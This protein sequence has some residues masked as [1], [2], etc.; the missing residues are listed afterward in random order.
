MQKFNINALVLHRIV[1]EEKSTFEDVSQDIFDEILARYRHSKNFLTID[2][3]F[4]E[5]IEKDCICLTFD[6]GFKSDLQIVL[7]K[8][9]E[10]NDAATFF[11]VKNYLNTDGY[12]NEKDVIELSNHGMQIGSHSVS[13]PNF[14][15]I[16]RLKIM[17]ELVS[18]RKYLEDL[19]SNKITTFSFPFGFTNKQ[20]INLVFEAGYKYCCTSQHGLVNNHSKIIPRNSINGSHTFKNVFHFIEPT[21]KTKSAWF[22][23]DIIKSNLK[24]ISPKFYKKLRNIIT[25]R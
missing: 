8:L 14:L 1:K 20:L 3:A 5:I 25:K 13:H 15:K 22:L 19:T 17:D 6:D 12:M 23:E 4:S 18:S 16:D 11:I 10:N 21:F 7:P 24:S 9:Q 2:D